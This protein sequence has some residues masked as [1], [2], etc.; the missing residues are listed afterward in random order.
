MRTRSPFP[1][2]A[3]RAQGTQ[4]PITGPAAAASA[5]TTASSARR[6]K[7]RANG[8]RST[9]GTRKTHRGPNMR[10]VAGAQESPACSMP[11]RARSPISTSQLQ[12]A[13]SREAPRRT[14][15]GAVLETRES[16]GTEGEVL[17]LPNPG[18][19]AFEV[20]SFYDSPNNPHRFFSIARTFLTRMAEI[21]GKGYP[22]AFYRSGKTR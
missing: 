18:G 17:T 2:P 7:S 13:V 15:D 14:R 16:T 22:R 4:N 1:S 20:N 5:G 21:R 19:I 6:R 9:G 12:I 8:S 3:S 11:H 10:K